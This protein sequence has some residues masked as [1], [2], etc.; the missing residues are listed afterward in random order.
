MKKKNNFALIM[1]LYLFGLFLG[2]LNTGIITP[3][4]PIIQNSLGV[5]EQTGIWMITIYTLCYAAIIPIAGK[6]ADRHGRKFIFII[7]IALFGVGSVICGI[8]AGMES[9][10]VL[11]AGRIVQAIGAGGIMPIATA[12]FGT[13]FPEEKRGMALGLVGAVYGIANVLGATV[14]SAILD[15]F[16]TGNWEWIFY[17]NVPLCLLIVAGSFIYVPNNRSEIVG[18]IDKLGTLLM[19]VIILSLLYGLKNIDFF[20]FLPSLTHTDVYPFLIAALVL[21]PLF[22]WTEKRAADPIFN[23][24]YLKNRQILIT[25]IISFFVGASMM[26]MIF[27]PQFSENALYIPTGSGG[28]FVIILGL[29]AGVASPVSG[30]LIDK[31]GAKPVLAGG[32]VISV[33]GCLYLCYITIPHLNIFNVILCLVL[34]GLGL[35]LTM[36]TPLNYMML[37]HTK[38]EESNSALA[39]L[40]LARSIGTAIAPAIMVGFLAQAGVCMQDNLMN[41]LPDLPEAP[42]LEQQEE[43][44]SILADLKKKNADNEDMKDMFA[45]MDEMSFDGS[46]KMDMDSMSD[47]DMELP[48]DL[49][50]GL[51]NADV[52]TIADETKEMVVYMFDT[53]TSPVITDI[54]EGINEGIDGIGEGIEGIGKGISGMKSGLSQMSAGKAKLQKGIDGVSQGIA[55]MESGLAQ[56]DKAI[57]ALEAMLSGKMPEGMGGE[58]SSGMPEGMGGEGSSGMP[59]GMGSGNEG[60]TGAGGSSGMSMDPAEAQ[61]KLDELKAAREQLNDKLTEAKAQRAQMQNALSQM[62]SGQNKLKKSIA[63]AEDQKAQMKRAQVLMGEMHDEIPGLFET[64]KDDYLASVDAESDKIE[65]VYQD[66]LNEGFKGM[67]ITVA[68][69]N[70]IALVLLLF[71]TEKRKKEESEE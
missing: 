60:G 7:S 17:L 31:I 36:G 14:G 63:D 71:Y 3:A 10:A 41:A 33:L 37:R 67:F 40:S 65:K 62:T 34:I 26:G 27:I 6:M 64:M 48:D 30:T 9:F 11:I 15:I 1:I 43:L 44:D 58:G 2:A 59:E 32:L 13:S 69:F 29:C 45:K 22:L 39:T 16:G 53:N 68:V 12:E 35:G 38:D 47:G 21:I 25:L 46:M 56:Q 4:R 5:G 61:Q 52:T 24:S 49:L 42:A 50:K 51:Q 70:A 8:S 19:T 57:A 66:T 18:P 23:L 55:G 20:D 54:Q 28:Y